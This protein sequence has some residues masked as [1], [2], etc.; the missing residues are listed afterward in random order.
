MGKM[1]EVSQFKV[2]LKQGEFP[3]VILLKFKSNFMRHNNGD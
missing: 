1:S 2:L 3:L